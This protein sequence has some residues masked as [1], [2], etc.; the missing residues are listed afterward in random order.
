MH[1]QLSAVLIGVE[2][3]N[4]AK[5]FY[6]EGLGCPIDKDYPAFVSFKLGEGSS[7]FGL[8][9]R[10]AL[11][12]DAGVTPDGN[13]FRAVTFSYIVP[14][15]EGVDEVMALAQRAGAKIVKPA[16]KAQYGYFGYFSDPDG[17]LWKVAAGN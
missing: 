2:D 14:S 12:A 7:E 8:Y 10:E 9:K 3:M 1:P 11:A 16:Q 13:G 4:R 6:A 17:H 15:A 5:R